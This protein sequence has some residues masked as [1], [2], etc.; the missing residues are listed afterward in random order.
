[1]KTFLKMVGW[2]LSAPVAFIVGLFLL[3]FA[4]IVHEVEIIPLENLPP[5]VMTVKRVSDLNESL[6]S[7]TTAVWEVGPLMICCEQEAMVA[8]ATEEGGLQLVHVY[9]AL[10][11]RGNS[12]ENDWQTVVQQWLALCEQEER[13]K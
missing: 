4:P 7:S 12:P 1:M 8:V 6:K 11:R 5:Y 3:S 2:L 9:P 10:A 13:G